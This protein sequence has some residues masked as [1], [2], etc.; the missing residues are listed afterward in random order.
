MAYTIKFTSQKKLPFIIEDYRY[1]GAGSPTGQHT[2]LKLF[3]K[4]SSDYG[5][6]LWT[7]LVRMLENHCNYQAPDAPTVGQLWFNSSGSGSINVCKPIQNGSKI[8][9]W[10]PLIDKQTLKELLSNPNFLE[11]G[12]LPHY[13]KLARN[14]TNLNGDLEISG[15]VRVSGH[16]YAMRTPTVENEVLTLGYFTKYINEN[17]GDSFVKLKSETQQDIDSIILFKKGVMIDA[18]LSKTEDTTVSNIIDLYEDWDFVTKNYVDKKITSSGLDWPTKFKD[19]VLVTDTDGVNVSFSKIMPSH[20]C[21]K[22]DNTKT[23]KTDDYVLTSDNTEVRWKP[24]G[25]TFVTVNGNN[26]KI[27]GTKVLMAAIKLGDD[28]EAAAGKVGQVL[29][30]NGPTAPPTWGE[31][32]KE[33]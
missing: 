11:T 33:L 8:N 17:I 14:G 26:Q 6:S 2:S 23:E 13:V 12:A 29:T 21:Y 7:N 10:I 1:D 28:A 15:N 16:L 25:D 9:N 27:N 22:V 24:T 18:K 5:E 3:G 31:G 20:I 19:T 32:G 30:S 4:G